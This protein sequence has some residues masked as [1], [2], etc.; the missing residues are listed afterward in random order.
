MLL[1]DLCGCLVFTSALPELLKYLLLTTLSSA[2][3][4]RG[5]WP[6]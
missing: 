3:R 4:L 2:P 5:G 1:S 6:P